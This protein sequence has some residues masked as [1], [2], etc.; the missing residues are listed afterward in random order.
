MDGIELDFSK[1][2]LEKFLHDSQKVYDVLY[3]V[4]IRRDTGII[5]DIF[6]S[7]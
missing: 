1:E 4:S 2:E 5:G 7:Y 3:E 6:Y